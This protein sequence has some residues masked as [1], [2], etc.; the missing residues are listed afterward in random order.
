MHFLPTIYRYSDYWCVRTSPFGRY[1][2]IYKTENQM[3]GKKASF[4]DDCRIYS[5][6]RIT[7]LG[8]SARYIN[9]RFQ[10]HV[11]RHQ[12]SKLFL[13]PSQFV[14]NI[15]WLLAIVYVAVEK[16]KTISKSNHGKHFTLDILYPLA[17][18]WL[19][20]WIYIHIFYFSNHPWLWYQNNWR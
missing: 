4:L 2:F 19:Y 17:A 11:H 12:K 3:M 16:L 15:S 14:G 6:K 13:F 9:C 1:L 5:M 10:N 18:T 7:K 20:Q 8:T